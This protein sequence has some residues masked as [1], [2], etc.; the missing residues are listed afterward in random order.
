MAVLALSRDLLTDYA[1]LEK[2]VRSKVFELADIFQRRSAQDLRN[3]KGTHLERYANQRDRRARTI[4]IDD[5]H[6]GVVLDVGDDET[7]VLTRVG[8][9]DEIDRWMLQNS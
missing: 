5:N 7:F 8:T 1:K 9:H 3:S 2:R 4:R 6:R